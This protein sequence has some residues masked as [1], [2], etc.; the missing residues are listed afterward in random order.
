MQQMQLLLFAF[1][2]AFGQ[3]LFKKAAIVSSASPIW[4]GLLNPWMFAALALYAG[5]TLLWVIILRTTPLSVAYPFAALA[6]VIVPLAARF[7]FAEPLDGRYALG[8][9]F[10]LAG[11]ILTSR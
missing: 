7:L 4:P 9:M 1:L 11:V 3:I 8:V 6:F 10:I 2:M 5:A